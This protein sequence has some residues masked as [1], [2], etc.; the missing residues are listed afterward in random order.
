MAT[1]R[2]HYVPQTYLNSWKTQVET[3]REPDKKFDG[4]YYFEEGSKIGDGRNVDTILWEPHLYT[5]GFDKLYIA[6]KC[7]LVYNQFVDMVFETMKNNKPFPV[8]GKLGYSVI[9]KKE[10]IRK[11]LHDIEKWD[12]FYYN[13]NPARRKNIINRVND[14]NCYI[15]EESFDSLFETQWQTIKNNFICDIKS[16]TSLPGYANEI[17]IDKTT[18]ENMLEFFIMMQCR[19][20][21][22]DPISVYSWAKSLL[23]NTFKDDEIAEE[24]I[25]SV[26]FTELY[27]MFYKTKGG[28][29]HTLFE[30]AKDNCQFILFEAYPNT[31]TFIT[32]DNPAFLH[33]SAVEA[34]NINGLYFPIDPTH[35]LLLGKGSE[36]I[37]IVSYRM[38]DIDTIRTFN[39]V[40][41]SHKTKA[42]VSCE[43]VLD[44][45]I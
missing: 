12:F 13:N 3:Q 5:I 30:R 29:Y 7:P 19:S 14:F 32:T 9:K 39:R 27:R 18:A 36:G 21:Q 16:K 20:P 17:Q 38:A 41:L 31:G 4:V 40:I 37:D 8:Y 43:D 42:I 10:S 34:K 6:K 45:I 15:L 26:W 35:M 25:E 22:F 24:M 23:K 2:Q 1:K 28:Y 33:M 44:R 11:H